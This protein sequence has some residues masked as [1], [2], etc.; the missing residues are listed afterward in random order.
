AVPGNARSRVRRAAE[1]DDVVA[2]LQQRRRELPV[3]TSDIQNG[4]AWRNAAQELEG[5]SRLEVEEPGA[6]AAGEPAR[7]VLGGRLDVRLLAVRARRWGR[8]GLGAA[9]R[10]HGS[11]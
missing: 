3:T 11:G 9:V 2:R 5:A 6:D 1:D 4:R 10:V 7:I 8:A